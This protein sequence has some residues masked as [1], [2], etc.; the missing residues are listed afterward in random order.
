EG[1]VGACRGFEADTAGC[2]FYINLRKAPF[3]DGNFSVFGQVTQGL[4][5]ARAIARQPVRRDDQNPEQD[6]R[7]LKPV[8]IRKVVIHSEVA[9]KRPKVGPGGQRRDAERMGGTSRSVS[10]SGAC[11]TAPGGDPRKG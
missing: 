9:K 8:A 6:H 11:V 7:P 2:R 3:L 1:V 5:V 10:N 4:D